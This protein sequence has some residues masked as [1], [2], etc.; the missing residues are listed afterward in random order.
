MNGKIM[1]ILVTSTI[2][3]YIISRT[4]CREHTVSTYRII[5]SSIPSHLHDFAKLLLE[6]LKTKLEE[7]NFSVKNSVEFFR[8]LKTIKIP[9]NYV[10]MSLDVTSFFTNV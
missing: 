3:I 6:N 4:I 5:V 9:E 7:S 10:M 8:M 1:N 2:N